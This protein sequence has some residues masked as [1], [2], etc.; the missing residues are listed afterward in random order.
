MYIVKLL[1]INYTYM[2]TLKFHI[3]GAVILVYERIYLLKKKNLT[4]ESIC[5]SVSLLYNIIAFR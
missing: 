5:P 3:H 4:K 2:Y 1:I